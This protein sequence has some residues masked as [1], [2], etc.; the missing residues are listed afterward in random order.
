MRIQSQRET[1]AYRIAMPRIGP[2]HYVFDYPEGRFTIKRLPDTLRKDKNYDRTGEL[3]PPWAL[4]RPE[5]GSGGNRSQAEPNSLH[6]TKQEAMQ[7]MQNW[8]EQ[9]DGWQP[10]V[11]YE[12][13]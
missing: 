10:H 2:G 13:Y 3:S 5:P 9:P 8:V 7:E 6:Q 1:F 4:H 11:N 12:R